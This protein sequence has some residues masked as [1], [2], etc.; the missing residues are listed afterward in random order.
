M[1]ALKGLQDLET[2]VQL[3]QSIHTTIRKILLSITADETLPTNW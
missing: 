3:K 2:V 1:V